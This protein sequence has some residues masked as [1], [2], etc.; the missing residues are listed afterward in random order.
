MLMASAQSSA[1]VFVTAKRPFSVTAACIAG[2]ARAGAFPSVFE[3][4]RAHLLEPLAA[5]AFLLTSRAWSVSY[6]VGGDQNHGWE[7]L[8]EE[9]S[10]DNQTAMVHAL[11]PTAYLLVRR[12]IEL[13][14]WLQHNVAARA[15]AADVMLEQ[16]RNGT[17]LP[18]ACRSWPLG[19][20]CVDD[21]DAM[22]GGYFMSAL[23][24]RVCLALVEES[25]RLAR[26]ATTRA[27]PANDTEASGSPAAQY[28]WV[29]RMRPDWLV[30]CRIE[31]GWPLRAP[32]VPEL[33]GTSRWFFF[34]YDFMLFLPRRG[35]EVALKL[36]TKASEMAK[37]S[38]KYG[39]A[40]NQMCV[41][42]LLLVHGFRGFQL[43]HHNTPA[44]L[45]R[46]CSDFAHDRLQKAPCQALEGVRPMDPLREGAC[47]FNLSELA[48]RQQDF[49]RVRHD[50][51]AV[52]CCD[53]C[54]VSKRL[55]SQV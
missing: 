5:D 46:A 41:I 12:D 14:T 51:F 37:S 22:L 25:E 6:H 36:L 55:A 40:H 52:A 7:G 16:S 49:C 1:D 10:L 9:I 32:H 30:R 4:T 31:T 47:P 18:P 44:T 3:R 35:A 48:R 15:V 34:Q 39:A 43:H 13:A 27:G 21:A 19:R 45:S 38:C 26:M 42:C 23:R 2:E 28:T 11:Q 53:G 54:K 50:Q 17:F 20:G 24:W 29:L 33:G 8:P